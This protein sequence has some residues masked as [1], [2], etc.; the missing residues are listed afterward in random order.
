MRCCVSLQV[1]ASGAALG[2]EAAGELFAR[3]T[4]VESLIVLLD[5]ELIELVFS[6]NK[7]L[8]STYL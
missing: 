6:L 4:T 2:A 7:R 3:R 1:L 8:S 5:R